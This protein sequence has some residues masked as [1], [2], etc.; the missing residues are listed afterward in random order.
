MQAPDTEAERRAKIQTAVLQLAQGKRFV[1]VDGVGYPAVGSVCGGP[2]ILLTCILHPPH[3]AFSLPHPQL[4]LISAACLCSVS[5][6]DVA[7]L[8]S[9]PVLL[10]S[11][12]GVGNAIDATCYMQAFF[13]HHHA[14]PIGVVYN[15][16]PSNAT[17]KAAHS[18]ER[19]VE[20]THKFFARWKPQLSVYGHVPV[21]GEEEKE[22]GEGEEEEKVC[23]V[24]G[25]KDGWE[26]SEKERARLS[27]WLAVCEG[28]ID[29]DRIVGDV[30]AHYAQQQAHGAAAHTQ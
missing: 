8:L 13:L 19:T 30:H 9:A 12:S 2:S 24:R 21:M 1:V 26:M 3:C 11:R 5:N 6:A 4:S 27:Q 18:Y 14:H 29:I 15:K 22:G 20:Y 28:H 23:M 25:G 16:V 17:A 7:H 10:V